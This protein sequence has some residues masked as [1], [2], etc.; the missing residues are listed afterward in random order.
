MALIDRLRKTKTEDTAGPAAEAPG[1]KVAPKKKAAP[2][3][4]KAETTEETTAPAAQA[5]VVTNHFAS[6][7]LVRPHV[8][9]KAA[10]LTERG[11]YTFDVPVSA[12][13]ISV[14]KAVEALYNVK[15]T[16]VRMIRHAGKPVYRGQ[17][18]TARNTW[19][20]ALVTLAKGQKLD[21]YQGV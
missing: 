12:E 3:V 14:R 7:A 6:N 21:L 16:D 8:S 15:V 5:K 20:K 10:L 11:V 18:V 2:K 1:K 4:K 13:K 17:R 9:E 19:K